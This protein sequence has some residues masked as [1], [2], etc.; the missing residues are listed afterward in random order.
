[1]LK[2]TKSANARLTE[3]LSNR[4]PQRTVRIDRRE[5]HLTLCRDRKRSGDITFS[6]EGRVVLVL[7][8]RLSEVLTGHTLDTQKTKT[9]T[10]L[11]LRRQ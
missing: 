5:K 9:G 3:L 2:L 6:H 8:S 7:D 4:S 10:R 11:R 1:M